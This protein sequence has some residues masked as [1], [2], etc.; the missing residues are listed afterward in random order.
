[1]KHFYKST[2]YSILMVTIII[3]P[4]LLLSRWLV[5]IFYGVKYLPS[6]KIIYI[7]WPYIVF[8]ALGIGLSSIFRTLNKMHIAIISN[9]IILILTTPLIYLAI[10]NYGLTGM[11]I[12]VLTW[13]FVPIFVLQIY[14]YYYLKKSVQRNI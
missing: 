8:T 14:S 9:L 13:T 6:V 5:E 4:M 7:L 3:I 1:K 2:L 10:K 12:A 11:V